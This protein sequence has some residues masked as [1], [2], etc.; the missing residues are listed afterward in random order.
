MDIEFDIHFLFLIKI[1][2]HSLIK[3]YEHSL[4]KIYKS[5]YFWYYDEG[6]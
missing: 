2:E 6:L 5:H 3:I 1:Y 4:I